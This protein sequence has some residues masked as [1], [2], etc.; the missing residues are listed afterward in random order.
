MTSRIS[1]AR[2]ALYTA[3]QAA[4]TAPWRVH[5][6][7]PVNPAAPCVWVGPYLQN[8]SGPAIVITF[9]VTAV[10]DGADR[11]Q[12]EGLDDIGAAISDAIW[13]A[14][15]RPVRSFSSTIQ[16]TGPS[17]RAIEY[18]ADFTVQGVTL[19]LPVLQEA[20]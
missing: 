5:R 9:P 16:V 6:T 10:Y 2:T 1:E 20:I 14:K 13:Q 11:A 3:L 17:L 19:C 18:Q 12:V 4:M 15:G 7:P 8:L